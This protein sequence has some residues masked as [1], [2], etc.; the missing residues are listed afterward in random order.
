M[1]DLAQ[2]LLENTKTQKLAK[3]AH[4]EALQKNEKMT[5]VV[6]DEESKTGCVILNLILTTKMLT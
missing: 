5:R 4:F 6:F 1:E 2:A 3:Q